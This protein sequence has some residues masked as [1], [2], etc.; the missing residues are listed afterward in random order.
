MIYESCVL[1]GY[2]HTRNN[3]IFSKMVWYDTLI[4]QEANHY[5]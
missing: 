3:I 1:V 4:T 5:K 2:L